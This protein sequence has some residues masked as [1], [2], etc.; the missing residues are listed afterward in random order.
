MKLYKSG[1]HIFNSSDLIKM[2]TNAPLY[3][4]NREVELVEFNDLFEVVFVRFKATGLLEQLKPTAVQL[5][6]NPIKLISENQL[7]NVAVL[8]SNVDN[9]RIANRTVIK[10]SVSC[11]L[12]SKRNMHIN[13]KGDVSLYVE[14]H[15]DEDNII[16]YRAV[17][18]QAL[19]AAY[20][21]HENFDIFELKKAGLATYA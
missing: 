1:S 15:D 9:L 17:N 8:A 12:D 19:I 14:D 13:E 6:L 18:N 21:I 7:R 4:G 16:K 20:L 11:T 10:E 5:R 3:C 2:Y